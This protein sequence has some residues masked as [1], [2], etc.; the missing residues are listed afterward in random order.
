MTTV[1]GYKISDAFINL[2]NHHRI[3]IKSIKIAALSDGMEDESLLVG[4]TV[5]QLSK[6][7]LIDSRFSVDRNVLIASIEV[8]KKECGSHEWCEQCP[9]S[10]NSGACMVDTVDFNPEDWDI[11]EMVD[12]EKR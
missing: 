8:I 10:S 1:K 3:E 5:E 2:E 9:L 7:Y 12:K 6:M 4:Y 11:Q